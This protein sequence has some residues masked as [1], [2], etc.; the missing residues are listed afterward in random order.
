MK[1]MSKAKRIAKKL[2]KKKTETDKS[3]NEGIVST[4][5]SGRPKHK[6]SS[7]KVKVE[8]SSTSPTSIVTTS[9]EDGN[10]N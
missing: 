1:S 10:D 3:D 2:K 6:T 7:G 9:S 4:T 8:G 5:T